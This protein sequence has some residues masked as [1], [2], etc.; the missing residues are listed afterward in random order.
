MTNLT[1]KRQ[2]LIELKE[3]KSTV[4]TG[5]NGVTYLEECNI[6][7]NDEGETFFCL[8]HNKELLCGDAKCE[9]RV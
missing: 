9:D 1:S 4:W 6:I 8:T 2:Q 3:I 5:T 7:T